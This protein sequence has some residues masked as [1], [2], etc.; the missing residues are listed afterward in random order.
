MRTTAMTV[1]ACK[2]MSG[3]VG[4]FWGVAEERDCFG[5]EPALFLRG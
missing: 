2:C 3:R 5:E 1:K 4:G